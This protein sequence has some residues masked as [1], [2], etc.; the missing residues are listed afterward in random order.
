MIENILRRTIP[1]SVL[2]KLAVMVNHVRVQTLDK[3]FYSEAIIPQADFILFRE[4][5]SLPELS[6]LNRIS[7]NAVKKGLSAFN[8]LMD[9][10]FI[11]H[12]K[13]GCIIEPVRGWAI[14]R[15]RQLIRFSHSAPE[16]RHLTKPLLR[17]T[18]ECRCEAHFKKVISFRETS[19]R[20]YFHFY[21]DLLAKIPLLIEHAVDVR[22][23]PIIISYATYHRSFFQ[24]MLLRSPFLNQLNWFVQ[25]NKPVYADEVIFCKPFTLQPV[26]FNWVAEQFHFPLKVTQYKRLFITRDKR[27]LRYIENMNELIPVLNKYQF[28]VVD[29]DNLSLSDQA[30]L[31]SNARYIAGI[32]G[33]GMTNIVFRKEQP[34]RLLEIFPPG[35]MIPYHYFILATRYGFEY[36]GITGYASNPVK[37]SFKVDPMKLEKE[38]ISLLEG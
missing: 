6:D 28:S 15:R 21:N 20:A 31:F 7:D 27:R 35:K 30:S 8:K 16:A 13:G 32:H 18:G 12:Y 36:N 10:E 23:T 34:L 26:Y 14:A 22:H 3:L 4:K 24:E 29:A 9:N 19:E 33:A 11:L 5:L 38:L 37:G 2:R 25:K 17:Y 1:R